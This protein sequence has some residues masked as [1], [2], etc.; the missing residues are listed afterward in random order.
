[1][2]GPGL[3]WS[4]NLQVDP[5]TDLQELDSISVRIFHEERSD[6]KIQGIVQSR[7][8]VPTGLVDR[9][10][11]R[12]D[13]PLQE[14]LDNILQAVNFQREMPVGVYWPKIRGR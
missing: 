10:L 12:G 4:E 3:R 5:S 7:D 13:A 14:K 6:S 2:R 1:M 9:E 11:V 8:V